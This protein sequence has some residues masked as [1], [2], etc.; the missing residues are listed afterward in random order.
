M[1]SGD[2]LVVLNPLANEP[3]AS[4]YATFDTRNGHP[5]LDFDPSCPQSAVFSGLLPRHYSGRGLRVVLVWSATNAVEIWSDLG[6]DADVL[7]DW[8]IIYANASNTD[9]FRLYW[10]LIIEGQYAFIRLY[11]RATKWPEDL[12]AHG[13]VPL[14]G[15]DCSLTELNDSH[16]FGQLDVAQISAPD[17]DDGNLLVTPRVKW[18][19]AFERMNESELLLDFDSFAAAAE[20]FAAPPCVCG[21]LRYTEIALAHGE[22]IDGLEAGE[23][24]RLKVA[25]CADDAEDTMPGDAELRLVIVKEL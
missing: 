22:A 23:P 13:M 8:Q 7:S 12:V 18:S 19:V 1:A 3:P 16:L 9:Q 14:A 11:K 2:T 6:D 24:F 10:S 17:T 20:V 21:R 4:G 15:G 25:R 5:V